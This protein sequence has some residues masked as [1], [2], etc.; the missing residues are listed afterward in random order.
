MQNLAKPLLIILLV[1][2]VP[3][4]PLL[5]WG[6]AFT[7]WL[8]AWREHPPAASTLVAGVITVLAA[9]IVLPVPSGPV[10]TLAGAQLGTLP[11]AAAGWIGTSLGALVGYA[12]AWRW[13]WPVAVRL[14]SRREL[15][16]LRRSGRISLPWLL[17]ISRPL[18][19]LAEATVLL[20]G[21][22]RLPARQGL[23]AVL[24]GNLLLAICFAALGQ[25]AAEQQRLLPALFATVLLP[26]CLGF[27]ARR[28]LLRIPARGNESGPPIP[29]NAPE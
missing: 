24:G 29:P 21:L 6:E 16:V 3:I 19:I 9:D 17:L 5:V 18:P 26:I 8:D 22:V 27:L 28:W 12:A 20:A 7:S 13:G 2:I 14:A 23:P 25:T 1:L 11:A 4:L 15:R 10:M